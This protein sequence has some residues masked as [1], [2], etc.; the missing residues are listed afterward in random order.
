MPPRP[1]CVTR[2]LARNH[3]TSELI[4]VVT[5]RTYASW[6]SAAAY[7]LVGYLPKGRGVYNADRA[8]GFGPLGRHGRLKGTKKSRAKIARRMEA[9]GIEPWS[10]SVS[11]TASTCVG[12]ILRRR[13]GPVTSRPSRGLSPRVLAPRAGASRGASPDLRF[14]TAAPG[15]LRMPKEREASLAQLTQPVPDRYWQVD[16]S[17]RFYQDLGPGH[18]A[19]PSTNP[20]KPVAPS[21]AWKIARIGPYR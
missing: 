17:K 15:G 8:A 7:R 14:D 12:G 3:V 20:S 18:A 4:S 10:E 9:Q 11:E 16:L 21:G 5:I 19:I 6:T 1:S 2:F 13:H